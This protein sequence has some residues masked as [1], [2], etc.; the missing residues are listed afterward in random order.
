M[1]T[2]TSLLA[3]TVPPQVRD[4]IDSCMEELAET[5]RKNLLSIQQTNEANQNELLKEISDVRGTLSTVNKLIDTD[6]T[7]RITKMK[8]FE[9]ASEL[10]L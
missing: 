7:H 9:D 2:K 5:N 10:G 8:L 3:R 1:I 4:Y 6:P